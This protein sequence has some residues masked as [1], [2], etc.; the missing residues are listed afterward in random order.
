MYKEILQEA[1]NGDL[2]SQNQLINDAFTA[3]GWQEFQNNLFSAI[4]DVDFNRF[5]SEDKKR[6]IVIVGNLLIDRIEEVANT[7]S[8]KQVAA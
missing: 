4:G 8:S 5:N 3:D 2:P 6:A 1:A 7:F